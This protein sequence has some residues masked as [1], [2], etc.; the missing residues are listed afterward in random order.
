MFENYNFENFN[1]LEIDFLNYNEDTAEVHENIIDVNWQKTDFI[2]FLD[3]IMKS[4]KSFGL[5][6]NVPFEKQFRVLKYQSLNYVKNLS[7][8]K[9]NLFSLSLVDEIDKDFIKKNM[10]CIKYKKEN[11]AIFQ[12]P[13]TSNLNDAYYLNRI[14]F[15]ITNLI[16]L[17]FEIMKKNEIEIFYRV[18]INFNNDKKNLEYSVIIKNLEDIIVKIKNLIN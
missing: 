5:K 17:N 6:N 14:I 9:I 4:N 3:K 1:Y 10:V 12:F 18:Y 15:K 16:F 2:N 7:D 13:S 11:M 8:N